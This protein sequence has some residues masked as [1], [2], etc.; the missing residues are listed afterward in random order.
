[1]QALLLIKLESKT[2]GTNMWPVIPDTK[3]DTDV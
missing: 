1:M 2:G 3:T